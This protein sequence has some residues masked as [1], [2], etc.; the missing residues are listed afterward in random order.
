VQ[1]EIEVLKAFQDLMHVEDQFAQCSGKYQNVIKV[2]D[3]VT[4]GDEVRELGV[5]ECLESGLC[6][7]QPKGHNR[8]LE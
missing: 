7:T 8:G 2:D 1:E 5:H 6:V 3:N 4:C